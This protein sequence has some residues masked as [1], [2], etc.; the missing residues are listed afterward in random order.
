MKPLHTS[1]VHMGP[2][3]G[4]HAVQTRSA[5]AFDRH[6]HNT[7][8]FGV[9]DEG[10]Q[11]SASGRGQVRALAGQIITT[12]PGEVHDGVPLQQHA[13]GWRMVYVTPQALSAMVGAASNLELTR[14]VLD[15]PLLRAVLDTLFRHW[16]P[17]NAA[18]G[19]S[20]LE[21]SLTQATGLLAQRYGQRRLHGERPVA[22]ERVRE[23]LL[24]QWA[25]PPTLATLAELAGLS[26][27][28]LVR[29]FSRLHGLPPFAWLQ[30]H[31][32]H[33][34]QAL[35]RQGLSLSDTALHCG[36]A[37]QSHLTRAFT[38]YLGYTP[39][40]WQRGH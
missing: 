11:V 34:A 27:Y 37:D 29:Q 6:W 38:R 14:P 23:C 2:L 15:D 25:A 8:G 3:P 26:R 31:R 36:F 7:F 9:M 30:Q 1:T 39:G 20:L 22:M 32:V 16:S 19:N 28:Q 18:D 17:Q 21:E 40:A 5:R 33:Q 12:N 13:R 10:G 24:D 35:I 4:V